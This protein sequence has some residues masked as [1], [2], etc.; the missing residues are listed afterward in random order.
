MNSGSV[1]VIGTS[2]MFNPSR[3]IRAG[4]EKGAEGVMGSGD[5]TV[6]D[7]GIGDDPKGRGAIGVGE[8]VGTGAI[9]KLSRR[10]LVRMFWR[11]TSGTKVT[12]GRGSITVFSRF[13]NG[14][15]LTG[16]DICPLVGFGFKG[17]T[18]LIFGF[19]I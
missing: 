9:T 5:G 14:S 13:T 7:V 1:G 4:N 18:W 10:G 15:M 16:L 12:S 19:L 3:E 11:F 17:R 8:G 6:G 2:G